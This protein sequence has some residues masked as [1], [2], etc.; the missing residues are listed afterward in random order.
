MIVLGTS[1]LRFDQDQ[2]D[3]KHHEVV[4]DIFV[5][6]ALAAW[7]L[8]QSH[9]FSQS[10]VIGFAVCRVKVADGIATLDANGHVR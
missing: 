10:F 9:S 6:E 7:T 1:Y 5:R 4:F 8:R 2:I 3:K